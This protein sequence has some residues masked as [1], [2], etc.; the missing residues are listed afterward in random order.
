MK[1]SFRCFLSI[2]GAAHAEYQVDAH[3]AD[4]T[5]PPEG[6]ASGP[7][8]SWD[9]DEG[10]GDTL[11]DRTGNGH[12]GIVHGARWVDGMRGKALAFSG[13]E[14]VEVPG[15]SATN[16]KSF[17][18]SIWLKQSGNGFRVPLME[19]HEPNAPVGAHLWAN[20]SGWGD[21]LPGA[22]YANLRPHD[23]SHSQ[24]SSVRERNLLNTGAGSAQGGRWNHVVL[25][26]DT[27][28]LTARIYVNGK[29]CVSRTLDPFLPFTTGS[30]FMGMRT[31]TSQDGDAGVGLVGLLDQADLF[32]R[33]L[34]GNRRLAAG[35]AADILLLDLAYLPQTSARAVPPGSRPQRGTPGRRYRAHAGVGTEACPQRRRSHPDPG[36]GRPPF[37][38]S[39][40][41]PADRGA[42]GHPRT[43]A[44]RPAASR[45]G[46]FR[47]LPPLLA[48]GAP[49]RAAGR[50]SARRL[51]P[52]R[53]V[54][55]PMSLRFSPGIRADRN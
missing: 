13:E 52:D 22:F 2:A 49:A 4:T 44:G 32:D 55:T 14:W 3:A 54:S 15:D 39:R 30:L 21:N 6:P 46:G 35:P 31:P 42:A 17:T 45:S 1:T 9:F 28:A 12:H 41:C 16:V 7:I 37:R 48:A 29:L 25:A 24:P 18:F 50:R 19:F 26:L 47:H 10:A 11:H 51:D 20:T 33:A 40:P 38:G 5:P 27:A 36:R 23:A 53:A 43:P 34:A 8:A